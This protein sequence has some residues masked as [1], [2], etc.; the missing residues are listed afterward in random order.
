MNPSYRQTMMVKIKICVMST[1]DQLYLKIM[2]L[3]HDKHKEKKKAPSS[4]PTDVM[5]IILQYAGLLPSNLNIDLDKLII[6]KTS[7]TD[8]EAE[9]RKQNFALKN[10]V[11]PERRL[12]PVCTLRRGQ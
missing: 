9:E 4:L 10:P 2:S 12:L 7:S 11:I 1:G 5:S 3:L 8:L 6:K